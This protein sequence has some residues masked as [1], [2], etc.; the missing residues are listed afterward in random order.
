MYFSDFILFVLDVFYSILY[1]LDVF[2]CISLIRYCNHATSH[3]AAHCLGG[4]GLN[5]K[6]PSTNSSKTRSVW[7]RMEN[8][9]TNLQTLTPKLRYTADIS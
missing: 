7:A 2:K 1:V 3:I 8:E 4:T 6:I 5:E 9:K